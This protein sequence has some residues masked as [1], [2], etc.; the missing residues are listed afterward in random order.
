MADIVE[1]KF[2]SKEK[3]QILLAEYNTL[4]AEIISRISST[5]GAVGIL[6]ALVTFVL[7]QPVGINFYTGLFIAIVGACVCGRFLAHDCFSAARRVRELEVAINE[8]AGE[9]LLLWESERGGFYAR[10]WREVLTFR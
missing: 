3:V 6:I 8:L 10:K 5:Y 7:Q 9:K 2:G 1:D 4:R